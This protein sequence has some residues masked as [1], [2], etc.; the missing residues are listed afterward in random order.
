[1]E[2][3]KLC[4][5]QEI[6]SVVLVKGDSNYSEILFSNGEALLLPRTLKVLEEAFKPYGFFRVHKSFLVNLKHIVQ[7]SIYCDKPKLLLSNNQEVEISRRKKSDFIK[8]KKT[9]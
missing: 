7:S 1:M 5:E 9:L 4:K 6:N 8:L 3:H 2:I